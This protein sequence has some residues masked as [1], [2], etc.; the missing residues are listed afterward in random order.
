VQAVPLTV[1]AVGLA[2]VELFQLARNPTLTLALAAIVE[3]QDAPVTVTVAPL[4]A[5]LPF[6]SC[7]MVWPLAN[8]QLSVQ[9][10]SA[11]PPVLVILTSPLEAARPLAGSQLSSSATPQNVIELI[12]DAWRPTPTARRRAGTNLQVRRAPRAARQPNLQVWLFPGQV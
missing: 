3:F 8:V 2:F 4:W 12:I 7:E 9:L 11:E 6:Q 5:K 10:L 1:N